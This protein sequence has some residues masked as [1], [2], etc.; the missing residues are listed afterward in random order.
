LLAILPAIALVGALAGIYGLYLLYI[1]MPKLKKTPVDKH[2]GYFIVS[3]LVMIGVYIILGLIMSRILM[4]GMGLYYRN[5]R[6]IY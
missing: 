3:L 2:A 5:S 6:V 4:P 1:G